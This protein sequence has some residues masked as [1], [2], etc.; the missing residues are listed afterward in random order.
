[1]RY[2][3]CTIAE[4]KV[5][6]CLSLSVAA[7]AFGAPTSSSAGASEPLSLF[8]PHAVG[9]GVSE[10]HMQQE[11][12]GNQFHEELQFRTVLGESVNSAIKLFGQVIQAP[13]LQAPPLRQKRLRQEESSHLTLLRESGGP[14]M[15][16]A[17][18]PDKKRAVLRLFGQDITPASPSRASKRQPRQLNRLGDTARS[19]RASRSNRPMLV[20]RVSLRQPLPVHLSIR[21]QLAYLQKWLP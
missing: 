9:F 3:A 16:P 11:Q 4:A 8:E 17:E 21:S 13:K 2:S 5:V 6:P 1:M 14:I 19:S 10:L 7:L 18:F 12:Q 20:R 15:M